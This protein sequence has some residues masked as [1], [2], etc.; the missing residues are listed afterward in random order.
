MIR[1]PPCPRMPVHSRRRSPGRRARLHRT[2]L[3]PQLPRNS[4]RMD[5]A[6][7][8]LWI[9]LR[10]DRGGMARRCPTAGIPLLDHKRALVMASTLFDKAAYDAGIRDAM[11]KVI[12]EWTFRYPGIERGRP[13]L[14]L[15]R[16]RRAPPATIKGIPGPGLRARTDTLPEPS[17]AS[18]G[19]GRR[20]ERLVYWR[21][22]SHTSSPAPA[23]V[24]AGP[25]LARAVPPRASDQ[26]AHRSGTGACCARSASRPQRSVPSWPVSNRVTGAP[27]PGSVR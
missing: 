9:R 15:Q 2:G 14:L 21:R 16:P 8:H 19:P 17:V 1:D 27:A 18:P 5:R 3:L 13:R 20:A 25:Y 11:D 6:R 24:P 4:A 7:V 22:S 23:A 12:D 26:R 10:A